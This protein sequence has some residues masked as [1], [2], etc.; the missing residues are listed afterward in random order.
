M[1]NI[2]LALKGQLPK[3]GEVNFSIV[4][5]NALPEVYRSPGISLVRIF[6]PV[7]IAV[8]IGALAYWGLLIRDIGIQTDALDAQTNALHSQMAILR[9]QADILRSQ[10]APIESDI[11]A[12]IE[13]VATLVQQIS[14]QIEANLQPIE[15]EITA[16]SLKAKLASL[17]QGLDKTNKD[18]TEAVNLVPTTVTLLSTNYGGGSTIINGVAPTE[19]DIFT[20]ARAL[21]ASDRFPTVII[22]SI[23][24]GEE[25]QTFNFE[26]LLK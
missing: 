7:A 16:N 24:E 17:G 21:R 25:I 8:A 23:E 10:Q 4:D 2:G 15:A 11:A 5:F 14:Q 26:F 19:D 12:Q 9:A 22:L 6:T 20:Y 1:V 13:A 18:L 3:G